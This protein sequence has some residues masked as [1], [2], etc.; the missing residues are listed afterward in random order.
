MKPILPMLCSLLLTL[1]ALPPGAV[2]ADS[3]SASLGW[4]LRQRGDD[5]ALYAR[6]RAG[7][8]YA[9]YR[10]EVRFDA[11]PDAVLAALEHNLFDPEALPANMRRTLVRRDAAAVV[12]HDYI[13]VPFLD[14]RDAVMRTEVLRDVEPGVHVVRWMAIE[15]EGPAP[16]EGVLRMPSSTGSWTLAPE[17]EGGTRAV[18][19]SH[20]ELGGSLPRGFVQSQ[21]EREILSQPEAVRRTLRERDLARR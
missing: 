10:M 20:T 2:L 19:Q 16:D 8:D 1:L 9:E 13:S 14:D 15:G 17:G 6:D 3:E 21:T 5:H 12:S 7:S 11:D 4:D 18:Y